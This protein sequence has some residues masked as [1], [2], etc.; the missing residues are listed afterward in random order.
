MIFGK[1]EDPN[2]K[3]QTGTWKIAIAIDADGTGDYHFY[4]QNNDGTW[5]HKPGASDVKNTDESGNLIY[6]P[7]TADRGIYECFVGFYYVG[8]EI[9]E[10]WYE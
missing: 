6:N 3:I 2:A 1:L 9:R 4:R 5:S 10:N 7:K 8:Y